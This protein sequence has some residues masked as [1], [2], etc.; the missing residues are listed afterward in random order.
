MPH[1]ALHDGHQSLHGCQDG[2]GANGQQ[3]FF[4]FL[5]IRNGK[6]GGPQLG[7]AREKLERIVPI[8]LVTVMP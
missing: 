5:A 8:K 3:G 4:I 7:D 6:L 1:G 2:L